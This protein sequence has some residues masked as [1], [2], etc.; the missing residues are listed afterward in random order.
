MIALAL[1]ACG[2]AYF[3]TTYRHSKH[4][5]MVKGLPFLGCVMDFVRDPISLVSRSFATHG[6]IF[7]TSLCGKRITWLIGP[8]AHQPF[9]RAPDEELDQQPIYQFTVPVFGKGVVYDAPPDIRAQQISTFL[10][11]SFS[12]A[13]MRTYVDVMLSEAESYFAAW[14][15]S[16]EVD[17]SHAFGELI[18]LTA[19]RCLMG[20]EVRE[21]LFKEVSHLY[22]DLEAGLTKISMFPYLSHLPIHAHRRRDAARAELVAIFSKVIRNR[23]DA[24][25]NAEHDFLQ[26]LVKGKY[27]DG[28]SL[29]DDEIVGMLIVLLFAGQ[30]TSSITATW[31]ALLVIRDAPLMQ[32]LLDEQEA[33]LAGGA[34]TY[35]GLAKME[36][37]HSCVSEALRMYPPL[38]FLM[39]Q[40]MKDVTIEGLTVPKGH[41]VGVCPV[42][43]GRD[44]AVFTDPH[45]CG[46][47]HACLCMSVVVWAWMRVRN[48]FDPD[49]FFERKEDQ[50]SPYNFIAFGAG[51]H[52]CMVH[53][54]LWRRL[55]Q[56]H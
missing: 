41:V 45:R 20:N 5:P 28:R 24:D 29:S 42:V 9:F 4:P 30:H 11:P 31:T 54:G 19:S 55:I 34:P 2:Y 38:V 47:T 56:L 53:R 21:N 1:T 50:S 12:T 26:V 23:R 43:A 6:S 8:C 10:A 18:I 35:D 36:L 51:K 33:V 49:R 3:A 15:Q 44:P 17:L 52:A 7:T 14:P 22:E 16:G 13:H 46:R 40:V 27:R 39:R 25:S 37:L 48:R 32:R